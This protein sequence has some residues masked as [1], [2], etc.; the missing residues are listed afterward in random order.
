MS[1]VR[2]MMKLYA[3]T[4]RALATGTTLAAQIELAAAN[5][6]TC[7]QLREKHLPHDEFLA[8]ARIALEICRRHGVPFIVND[9]V[10]IARLCGA[11]GVHVGQTDMHARDVRALIGH[12][13]LLGVS[14]DTVEQALTAE[15]DGADYLGVGA[16]F[17]TPTKP[18]ADLVSF[19][20]LREIC[21]AVS[22]PVVAIGGIDEGNIAEL[23]GT[24]ASGAAVVRAVFGA[25]DIAAAT[26]RLRAAA[27]KIF[28]R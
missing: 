28:G 15:R 18:D 5:G 10:E 1:S 21:G 7:I 27:D 20:T 4:D 9:D 23:K 8:E 13:M 16:L 24:G 3:V 17:A 22:I 19:D 11:D 26:A 25:D 12:D 6:A 14:A 2:Q